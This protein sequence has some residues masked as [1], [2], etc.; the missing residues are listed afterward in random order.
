TAYFFLLK[1]I[2]VPWNF[3]IVFKYKTKV[4]FCV[5]Q[6]KSNSKKGRSVQFAIN[7]RGV[8]VIESDT[9]TRLMD[10]SL[11]RISYCSADATYGHVFAFISTN[12]NDSLT[13]HAFLCSKR[14]MA[15][16]ISIT[17]AQ[18]FNTAFHLWQM[19]HNGMMPSM[20]EKSMDNFITGCIKSRDA[21]ENR[22]TNVIQ[23]VLA[24]IPMLID[25][26]TPISEKPPRQWTSFD[27]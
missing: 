3:K 23:Q 21:E 1:L 22:P 19:T 13:C 15:Q 16:L 7:L 20:K 5:F 6:A 11:Y 24:P 8:T 27:D 2:P 9:Q 12:E 4:S 26:T 17:V 25:L 18:T 10:I 14:K